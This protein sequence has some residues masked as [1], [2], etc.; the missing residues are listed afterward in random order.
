MVPTALVLAMTLIITTELFVCTNNGFVGDCVIR[1]AQRVA[2]L[3]HPYVCFTQ[4]VYCIIT[5]I[6][7]M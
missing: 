3:F 7:H 6:G 5:A 4:R 2:M 1:L